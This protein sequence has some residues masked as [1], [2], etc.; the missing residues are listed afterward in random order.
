MPL[1][2]T[3]SVRDLRDLVSISDVK[4]D[5]KS[6]DKS[7]VK[8]DTSPKSN[9]VEKK[10]DFKKFIHTNINKHT[11]N[12]NSRVNNKTYGTMLVLLHGSKSI[13][14]NNIIDNYL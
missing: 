11:K 10:Y 13:S 4:S 12:I 6:D 9:L 3:K 5:V 7:D 1:I 8:S 14:V 2:R